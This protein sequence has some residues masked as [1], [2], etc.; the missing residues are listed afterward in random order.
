MI[1]R[2]GDHISLATEH[3]LH[4]LRNAYHPLPC[5]GKAPMPKGWQQKL[6][7]N[8][9]EIN[10]WAITWP[11]AINTG[12]LCRFTPCLDIDVL[13][14]DAAIAIEQMVR[15]RF[16][17]S[18]YVLVRIG[19]APKRAIPFRT[20][21]PF[22]KITMPLIAPNGDTSQ[23]LEFLGN[24]QQVIVDGIHPDTD[25]PYAWFGKSPLEVRHD[26]LPYI[27]ADE[28]QQLIDDIA[29]LLVA[30]FGY[31]RADR[32]EKKANG[33]ADEPGER[34]DWAELINKIIAGQELHD[35]TRDLAASYL[36]SGMTAAHAL[37]QLR[38]LMLTSNV[39]HDERWQTRFDDLPRIVRDAETKFGKATDEPR[40]LRD[41]SAQ[42]VADFVPPDYVLD[43]V[44]QRRFLYSFTGRTGSGKTAVVLLIAASVALGRNIGALEVAKGRVFYFCGENPDDVRMRWIALAQQ[45]DFDID[46]IAVDFFPGRFKISEMRER[47][48]AEAQ[49]AGGV[50]LIIIDTSAAYYEDDDPNNNAQQAKHARRLRTLAD[51]PGGPAVLVNCHPVKNAAAD[52]LIPY[53]GGAFTNEVDG[54][55]TCAI[56]NAAIEVSWQGKFRGPDFAPLAFK[57]RS[58]THERLKDSKGRLIPTVI[59][60]HLS[61]IGQEE[62][63]KVARS[64]EDQLLAEIARDGKAS[65]AELARRCGW[66][67]RDGRTPY[68]TQANRILAKLKKVK[69]VT[70]DERDGIALTDKGA[71]AAAKT[72]SG[73][74]TAGHNQAPR[75]TFETA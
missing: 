58:V 11:T 56:D 72:V 70:V 31:R 71:K 52:N 9:A 65:L 3:R 33:G 63:A 25:K 39:A 40:R 62:M 36:G 53:G 26:E 18:G 57:V 49:A 67:Q 74:E 68:K 20:Q 37:R 27:R 61:E 59:A 69:L 32:R 60:E 29:A 22:A 12:V 7:T 6:E 44:L 19:K 42:F 51:L 50:V 35:S 21:E 75:F 13:D 34:A 73:A 15:G 2:G 10:L 47:I 1:D 5:T 66:F 64:H 24:G 54:N 17:E 16:E 38:A 8:D 28:A 23:K 30:E 48:V 14:A 4:L 41:T 55:L 43:G 46:T 45:M